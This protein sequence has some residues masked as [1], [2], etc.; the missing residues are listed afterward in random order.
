MN[1]QGVSEKARQ[2]QAELAPQL[3]NAR[4]RLSELN[5]QTVSFIRKHPGVSLLGALAFGYVVGRIAT[6]GRR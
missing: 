5:E 6:R 3:E 1:T 2:I 4:E